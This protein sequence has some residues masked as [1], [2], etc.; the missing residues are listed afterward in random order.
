MRD[1]VIGNQLAEVLLADRA[2]PRALL[3]F[4]RQEGIGGNVEQTG[5]ALPKGSGNLRDAEVMEGKGTTECF[6]KADRGIN[7]FAKLLERIRRTGRGSRRHDRV[8]RRGRTESPRREGEDIRVMQGQTLPQI[9]LELTIGVD[10]DGTSPGGDGGRGV[11]AEIEARNGHGLFRL[12]MPDA[13]FSVL[14]LFEFRT[15]GNQAKLVR[16]AQ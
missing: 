4:R 9:L 3:G 12:P 14:V 7:L 5:P 10:I 8:C 2:Q 16:P 6:V 15:G 1:L 13:E 11:F